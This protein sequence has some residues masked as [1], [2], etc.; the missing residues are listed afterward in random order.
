MNQVIKNSD[1]E[2]ILQTYELFADIE[3]L[4]N[5]HIPTLDAKI[6]WCGI[7]EAAKKLCVNPVV[8]LDAGCGSSNLSLA[9]KKQFETIEKIYCID[10]EPISHKLRSNEICECIQSDIFSAC[11]NYVPDESIDIIVDACSVTHFNI[12]NQEAPNDGCYKF[13]LESKRILKT[14]GIYIT[15][16]DFSIDENK[17]GEF[18]DI[19][20]M[21]AS[22]RKGGLE[23]IDN[24]LSFDL[25]DAFISFKP[26]NLGIVRLVF[27]KK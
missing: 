16:S 1:V 18:V 22:Y 15:C 11:S 4:S 6:K 7:L 14:G 8:L 2:K 23:L 13:A 9:L 20:S 10:A 26:R 24:N 27:I 21:I 19:E 12:T 5:G 17:T 3:P 25:N